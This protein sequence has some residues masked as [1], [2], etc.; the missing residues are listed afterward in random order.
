[1]VLT[2]L[3]VCLIACV[4][5]ELWIL[6]CIPSVSP[7]TWAPL[8]T[9]TK[10]LRISKKKTS[11]LADSHSG[12]TLWD[13][14]VSP[15]LCLTV[16]HW[17]P[18]S[19]DRGV[20]QA[21]IKTHLNR[22]EIRVEMLDLYRY[23]ISIWDSDLN[24]DFQSPRGPSTEETK[25]SPQHVTSLQSVLGCMRGPFSNAFTK[26]LWKVYFH[27]RT[28]ME[29]PPRETCVRLRGTLKCP[30]QGPTTLH[31]KTIV[32]TQTLKHHTDYR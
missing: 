10:R 8:T 31:L 19:P 28:L 2:R 7:W 29:P 21:N 6:W 24:V 13:E 22:I 11:R 18:L 16:R 9:C 14:F 1:M 30:T 25:V 20:H 17:P 12:A 23:R 27:H 32:N 26:V 4:I 5:K 3:S 15:A